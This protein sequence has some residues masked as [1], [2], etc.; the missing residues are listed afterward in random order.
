MVLCIVTPIGIGAVPMNDCVVASQR[1]VD[2]SRLPALPK[3]EK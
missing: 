1:N 2:S 3:N